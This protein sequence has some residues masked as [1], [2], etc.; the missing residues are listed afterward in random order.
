MALLILGIVL[1]WAAHLFKRLAPAQR[2]ALG[3]KGKGLMA[4]VLLG[5]VALMIVG[6]RGAEFIHVWAPPPAF[7]HVNNALMVLALFFTSPGPRKGTLF[8]KMRHPQ[9]FGF[10]LWAVAHLLVNGDLAAMLLFGSM[11]AWAGVE[12]V[13]INRA[14]P[15]WTPGPRGSVAKGLMFLV[16]SILLVGVIGYIHGLIGPSPF[17]G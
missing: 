2:A 4:L 12:V 14:E 13:L 3:H 9:L 8:Y 6:F 5:A 1:W 7:V 17:P 15:N 16:I 10:S 11:L